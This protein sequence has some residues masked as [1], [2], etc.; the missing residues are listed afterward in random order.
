VPA[1]GRFEPDGATVMLDALDADRRWS[2]EFGRFVGTS[3]NSGR[4]YDE[5]H[6]RPADDPGRA[7]AVI[8]GRAWDLDRWLWGRDDGS[9][10]ID[11]SGSGALVSSLREI[12]VA[13]TQ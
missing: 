12:V 7:D 11:V 5:P 6:A 8:A 4:S 9:A 2:L 1:W 10:S 13:V 3:P